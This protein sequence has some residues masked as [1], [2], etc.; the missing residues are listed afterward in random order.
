R[1]DRE[2]Y[3]RWLLYGVFQPVH[4]PHAQEHIAPEPVFHDRDTRRL[5]RDFVRLRYALLP[6][7]YTLAWQHATT[8][9]P[10]MRPLAFLDPADP[11]LLDRRDAYLWGDALLVA[12]VVKPGVRQTRVD[13]PKGIWFDY[14][15]GKRHVGP[16]RVSVD[17]P[18]HR[19]PVFARAGAFLPMIEPVERSDDYSTRALTLH[20]WHEPGLPESTGQLYDDDGRTFASHQGSA[21]EIVDF[22]ARNRDTDTTLRFARRGGDYPGRPEQRRITLVLHHWPDA[23]GTLTLD[24]KAITDLPG[25]R[26]VH[27]RRTRRLTVVFDWRGESA[28]LRLTSTPR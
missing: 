4:R 22:S 8:G 24:G 1:F 7:H 11:S 27:D 15:T 14:W 16:A 25:T 3:L 18:L 20:H 9:L 26:V 10:L 13:L 2:L 5:A 28:E 21:H 6:Y 12:P 19:I 17:T 23:P